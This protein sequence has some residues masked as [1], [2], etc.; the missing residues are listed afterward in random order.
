MD[1]RAAHE[2]GRVP[3]SWL[4]SMAL[5]SRDRVNREKNS[6]E[7]GASSLH[8][9]EHGEAA[10]ALRQGPLQVHAIQLPKN[11]RA[12]LRGGENSKRNK[13][14]V[15]PHSQGSSPPAIHPPLAGVERPDGD[16][17]LSLSP[18]PRGVE[19]PQIETFLVPNLSCPPPLGEPHLTSPRKIRQSSPRQSSCLLQILPSPTRICIE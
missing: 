3:Y 10:E 9:G 17:P 8:E 1:D 12:V 16:P 4:V 5:G 14:A 15:G 13:M 6:V 7:G 18:S 19:S 2:E 11:Q